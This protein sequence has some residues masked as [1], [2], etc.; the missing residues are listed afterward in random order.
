MVFCH[1]LF[2]LTVRGFVIS[3]DSGV[4]EHV[5]IGA[6]NVRVFGSTK[7][8]NPEVMDILV[9]VRLCQYLNKY[10]HRYSLNRE[11]SLNYHV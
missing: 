11:I 9:K 7:A 10:M 3:E 8:S 4:G 5:M 2:F 1:L 6:F